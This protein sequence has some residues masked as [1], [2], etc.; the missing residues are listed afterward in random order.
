M[1]GHFLEV[2]KGLVE[3]LRPQV[4]MATVAWQPPTKL[5]LDGDFICDDR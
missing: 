2:V 3:P 4:R 5:W 1:I